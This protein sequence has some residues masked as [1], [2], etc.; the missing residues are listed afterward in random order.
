M[1]PE[2]SCIE[3]GAKT[4]SNVSIVFGVGFCSRILK[5]QRSSKWVQINME[6]LIC[7]FESVN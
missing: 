1:K 3:L 7:I 2:D 5:L 4:D 6:T